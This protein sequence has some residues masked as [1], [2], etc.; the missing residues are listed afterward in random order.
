MRF[1]RGLL[2]R[3]DDQLRRKAERLV[4]SARINATSLF[5][6][7]IDQHALL[8]NVKTEQW[9]FVVTIAGVFIATTRLWN[10]KIGDQREQE[11]TDII[12]RGLAH[13]DPNNGIPGVEDCKATFERNFDAFT[14]AQH[15]PRFI[16]SDSV[17]WW[18]V[19]NLLMRAPEGSEEER[20]LVRII[21][22]AITYVFFL[23]ERV[24]LLCAPPLL[25]SGIPARRW[26]LGNLRNRRVEAR[27]MPF[28]Q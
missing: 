24:S 27:A 22:A 2:S 9:D 21:G 4:S 25:A 19:C 15:E 14:R 18:V 23:V 10:L 12:M 3:K 7:T 26:T 11:L 8:R 5:A 13:W 1:L 16:A 28:R 6:P 20:K 17:G